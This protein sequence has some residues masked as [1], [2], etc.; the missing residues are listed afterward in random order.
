MT[1]YLLLVAPA[2]LLAILG[3]NLPNSLDELRMPQ[4]WSLPVELLLALLLVILAG[5]R[6]GRQLAR[7]LGLILAL[8]ILVRI[9]DRL[10]WLW[11]GRELVIA[12]DIELVLPLLEVS[13]GGWRFLPLAAVVALL[14]SCALLLAWPLVKGLQAMAGLP[15]PLALA[16][17]L[18]ASLW[19]MGGPISAAGFTQVKNQVARLADARTAQ[20]R[21]QAAL[22][23]DDWRRALPAELFPQLR[24]VDV[25]VVFVESYGRSSF[26]QPEVA[27]AVGPSL[28]RFAAAAHDAGKILVSGYLRSPTVGG[29]SWLAHATVASGIR[30]T[31]QGGWRVYLQSA[32]ADLAHLFGRAGHAT[33][34]VQPAIVRPFPE[35]DRLGFDRLLFA[36]ELDY[37]GPRPGYVTMPDQFTL[38]RVEQLLDDQVGGPSYGQVALIGSHAP[39]TPPVPRPVPWA[40]MADGHVFAGQIEPGM[41][42]APLWADTNALLDA[43]KDTIA[44]TL[45]V[46]AGWVMLPSARPRLVLL[47]GDHE[48]AARVLGRSPGYDVP[49]HVL[50]TSPDLAAPFRRLGFVDGARPDPS[51][52]PVGM[53]S[54][55]KIML[56]GFAHQRHPKLAS[57]DGTAQ[58]E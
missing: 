20:M 24:D 41:D 45:D 36:E 19:L 30:T 53:E 35:A 6:L 16:P 2:F 56:D 29:Q 14:A 32:D 33:F 9:G 4:F 52:E 31:G 21:F 25:L 47:L 26:D 50:A 17:A 48:P 8:M 49:L 22:A 23:T 27:T 1:R 15:R 38:H 44:R 12:T 55:R 39:F 10:L 40:G 11:F 5:A 42:P 7:V 43:Y 58:L 46:L 3:L 13:S 18:A 57:T 51:V 37:R 28:D 34:M 54:L